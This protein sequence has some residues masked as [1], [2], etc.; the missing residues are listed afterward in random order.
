MIS[1]TPQIFFEP[2]KVLAPMNRKTEMVLKLTGGYARKVMKQ[3]MRR[4]KGA[5]APGD[6]PSVHSGQLR[7]LIYFGYDIDARELVVGPTLF[8][9]DREISGTSKTVPELL[10]EGGTVQ[11]T[12]V[13]G[14][15]SKRRATD[16]TRTQTYRPRPYVTL[17]LPIAAKQFAI[18]M[19]KLDLK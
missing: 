18:N 12:R 11:R 2:D 19:E 15:G 4:R 6:Y 16:R 5:S 10:N 13:V 3:G 7:D 1:V 9:V 14:R 8:K 17:T